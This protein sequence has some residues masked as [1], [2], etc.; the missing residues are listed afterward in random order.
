MQLASNAG[1]GAG[2]GGNKNA[3]LG[4]SAVL[5]AAATSGFAGVYF[6]KVLKGS[7]MSVWVRLL[8]FHTPRVRRS[9]LNLFSLM[10]SPSLCSSSPSHLTSQNFPVIVW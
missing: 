2:D 7:D 9:V 1:G 4:V 10:I 3:V 8:S 6:E 5:A